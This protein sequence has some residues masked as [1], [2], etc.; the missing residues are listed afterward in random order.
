[1]LYGFNQPPQLHVLANWSEVHYLA[2]PNDSYKV[3]SLPARPFIFLI[4]GTGV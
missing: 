1:M 2:V 4:Y 3:T